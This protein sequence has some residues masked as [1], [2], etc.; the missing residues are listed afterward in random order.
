MS[1]KHVIYVFRQINRSE[2]EYRGE[3]DRIHSYGLIFHH[4]SI[5]N[6]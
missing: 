2:L 1:Y 3:D 5:E 4:V 6:D